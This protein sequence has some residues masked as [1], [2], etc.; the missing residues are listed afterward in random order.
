MRIS[1]CLKLMTSILGLLLIMAAIPAFGDNSATRPEGVSTFRTPIPNSVMREGA[2]PDILLIQ[3]AIPWNSNANTIVLDQLGYTYKAIDMTEVPS[4]NIGDYQVVLIVNDQNQAFYDNYANNYQAFV[5]Y[6]QAGGVLVF[7]AC[8]KGWANGD[9]HTDLPGGIK[10]G[11]EYQNFNVIV[12]STHPIITQE[13]TANANRPLTNADLNSTYCS[14]NYFMENSLPDGARI[15]LRDSNHN[16]PTLVEYRL[17]NGRV[18]A[19]GLTW[20]YTYDRYTGPGVRFGFG[21]ALPDVFKYAFSVATG[22]QTPKDK[23][24]LGI[25][26]EDNWTAQNRPSVYKHPGDLVDI[27]GFV[28]N[29]SN[30][31]HTIDLTFEVEPAAAFDSTFAHVYSRKSA[32]EIITT[33]PVEV[34]VASNTVNGTKRTVKITGVNVR[35]ESVQPYNDFVLRLRIRDDYRATTVIN[36]SATMEGDTV[37]TLTKSLSDSMPSGRPPIVLTTNG[38]I[39]ITNRRQ[40]YKLFGSDALKAGMGNLWDAVYHVAEAQKAVLYHLD[41]YDMYAPYDPNDNPLHSWNTD[42]S[43]LPYDNDPQTTSNTERDD[44]NAVADLV[45]DMLTDIIDHSGGVGNGRYVAILGNDRVVPFYRAFDPAKVVLSSSGHHNISAV[46][47]RDA[48]N[49]H[50]Y[51]DALYRDYNNA[52]WQDTGNH[53]ENIFVG[54]ILGKTPIDMASLLNSS[55]TTAS[56]SDNVVKLENDRRDGELDFYQQESL[57]QGYTVINSVDG[58]TLDYTWQSQC[59][60]WDLLC[61]HNEQRD[62]DKAHWAEFEKLYTGTA[63]NVSDFDIFRAMT[64]GSTSSISSSEPFYHSY[65][66]ATDLDGRQNDIAA[67]LD[68]FKPFFIY[69]ACLVGLT[70]GLGGTFLHSLVPLRTRG[71]LASTSVTVTPPISDFNDLFYEEFLSSDAGRALNRACNTF[72][73]GNNNYAAMTRFQMNLYGLPWAGMTPPNSRRRAYGRQMPADLGKLQVVDSAIT[74]AVGGL[75]KNLTVD[76][77]NYQAVTTQD[78]YDLILIDGF[79]LDRVDENTPVLPINQYLVDLPTDSTD[80]SV[81]CGKSDQ[82]NLGDKNIPGYRPPE[83]MPSE[84]SQPEAYVDLPDGL[85]VYPDQTCQYEI[86]KVDGAA[87]VVLDVRPVTIDADQKQTTLYRNINITVAYNTSV[88]GVV[89]KAG[90]NKSGYSPGE[91]ITVQTLVENTSDQAAAFNLNVRILDQLDN[92]VKNGSNSLDISSGNEGTIAANLNAP[93]DPGYYTLAYTVTSGG[94]DIGSGEFSIHVRDANLGEFNIPQAIKIGEYGVF[95]LKITNLSNA[96]LDCYVDYH[97][98]SG[99]NEAA[100]LPQ[101]SVQDIPVGETRSAATQWYPADSLPSGV[102]EV[103]AVVSIGEYTMSTSKQSF[104]IHRGEAAGGSALPAIML[105]LL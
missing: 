37:E 38:K 49:N 66:R 45:D 65:Y 102:Y 48:D 99:Q 71:I 94:A 8:D 32:E 64:H 39:I 67:H 46:A 75:N 30:T 97:I 40:L 22:G 34:Q 98:Y 5:D 25:Y 90:V 85:G 87:R 31:D 79:R 61:K 104:T 103:Q 1:R 43:N 96:A 63:Q 95:S 13:L 78:G 11:D 83:P 68:G 92:V 82:V 101:I 4:T 58:V 100:K 17:D 18:I 59:A 29:P 7:F 20:E 19:S 21:R 50:M 52:G 33:E 93:D 70:D 105:L 60:W 76:A 89:R 12:D 54:R 80:I 3:T 14:H 51:T 35:Q 74:R 55:N 77:S 81:T 24:T 44:V 2:V 72:T 57:D 47:R 73:Y 9:N 16:Y 88:S 10:V 41:K 53:L 42:R 69:D 36:A 6:V 23:I 86:T 15:I 84:D 56:T 91:S 28:V 27:V 26:P 62:D